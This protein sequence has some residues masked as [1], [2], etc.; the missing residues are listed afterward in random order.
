VIARARGGERIE[1]FESERLRKGGERI[2]V[3]SS[4]LP[5][6]GRM[7]AFIAVVRQDLRQQRLAEEAL[8]KSEAAFRALVELSP[9]PIFVHRRGVLVYANPAL[10]ALSGYAADEVIGRSLLETLV[11]PTARELVERRIQESVVSLGPL[12][13]IEVAVRRRDGSVLI[14]ETVASRIDF[15]GEAATLILGRDITERK[16][17][18]SRLMVSTRMASIGTLAAGVAHEINNP[19]A[20]VLGNLEVAADEIREIGGASPSER[21]RKLEETL[22]HAQAGAEQIARIV[23]GLKVFSRAEEERRVALDVHEVIEIA[24]KMSFN[25][26]RHRARLVRDQSPLP[27]VEADEARLCQVFVNLLVNAAQA[28]R[29]GDADHNEIRLTTRTDAGG[30]A[31]IEV[32]DTGCGIPAERMGR[33]FDPFFTTKPV[34]VGTGLGLSICH[35]IV[36][37]LGGEI[38]VES[39]PSRGS[40]FRVALPPARVIGAPLAQARSETPAPRPGRI[41][42]VDDNIRVGGVVA[43]MLP[44]HEVTVVT[45]GTE[46]LQRI[47]TEAAY[48][49]IIC[50]LMMPEM[51]GMDLHERLS[52]ERP[53]VATRLVFM[54]GGAFTPRARAFL[55]STSA[56][57]LEKPFKKQD[58]LALLHAL[59]RP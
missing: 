46:A 18:Q 19:L 8:R 43:A 27:R 39:A 15:A 13:P 58:L 36:A 11:H 50:D 32:R 20:Y 17:L 10:L 24:I 3:I 42:V 12:P 53:E 6:P 1:S 41:L 52:A 30:R 57:R 44:E 9:E 28:I 26:V 38:T 31:V 40:V 16:Q 21:L 48:D 4:L 56:G 37:G 47:G 2:P 33:I 23:Q 45:S 49:A 34:G 59:L 22:G 54:T 7:G 29:E 55:E 14:A 51:S 35:G 25:E 5:L